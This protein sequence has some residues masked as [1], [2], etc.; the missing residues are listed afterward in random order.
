MLCFEVRHY[1]DEKALLAATDTCFTKRYRVSRFLIESEHIVFEFREVTSSQHVR[2]Y[3][4]S[5][6]LQ[7]KKNH[8]VV[9]DDKRSFIGGVE[10]MCSEIN[11]HCGVLTRTG[12]F[13]NS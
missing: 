7:I 9:Y 8:R 4:H 11:K 6:V 13:M 10:V 2:K 1:T 3:W 12:F 5:E